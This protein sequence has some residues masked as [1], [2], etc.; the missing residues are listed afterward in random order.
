MHL[1]PVLLQIIKESKN[2]VLSVF[3]NCN[4]HLVFTVEEEDEKNW[5]P[6]FDIK[7]VR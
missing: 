4:L 6:F 1:A 7:I 2:L 3:N 5:I